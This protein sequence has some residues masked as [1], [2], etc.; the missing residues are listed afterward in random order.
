[1]NRELRLKWVT[2]NRLESDSS[3]SES[4]FL[5]YLD[6]KVPDSVPEGQEVPE[7]EP[8]YEKQNKKK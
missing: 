4:E 8:D 6:N 7:E 5:E 3:D 1:M 2:E